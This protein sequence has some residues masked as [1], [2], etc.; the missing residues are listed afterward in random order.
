IP[1]GMVSNTW[2]QVS[3]PDTVAITNANS[4]TNYVQFDMDGEF[5][6][7]LIGDD[8]QVKVF[9]DVTNEVIEPTRV[10]I[11]A[12][13]SDAAE[14]G[15]DTGEFTFVRTGD[16]NFD[17]TVFLSPGGTASNGVDFITLSNVVVLPAGQ[18]TVRW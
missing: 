6:F 7:R 1:P 13:D 18:D 11:F 2:L 17:M 3:G 9:Q 10:D 16:T 8:G 14:L 4:L 15:P 5:V 12:S